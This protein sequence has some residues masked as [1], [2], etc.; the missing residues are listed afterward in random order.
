MISEKSKFKR[1]KVDSQLPPKQKKTHHPCPNTVDDPTP[2]K[3]EASSPIQTKLEAEDVTKSEKEN[4]Y[5]G[6]LKNV[7]VAEDRRRG[8]KGK[9]PEEDYYSP[10]QDV[11][12]TSRSISDNDTT[13]IKR[14]FPWT[15]N[16][17]KTS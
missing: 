10:D 6:V 16:T 14:M 4:I 8:G 13:N 2:L 11:D 15:E 17:N 3:E 7:E 1:H 12:S 9:I 5:F